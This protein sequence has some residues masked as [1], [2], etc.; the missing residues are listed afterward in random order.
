MGKQKLDQLLKQLE[1]NHAQDIENAAAIFTVAQGAVNQLAA[2]S[3]QP[4]LPESEVPLAG[5]SPVTKADLLERYGSYNACRQAA[6]RAGITF[7][8]TP[9]WA[10]L[11][12]AFSYLLACQACVSTYLQQ[13][14][15]PNLKGV[16]IKLTLSP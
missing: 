5:P 8:H 3:S 2:D 6:K 13:H 10:Q 16:S 7:S 12:T 4:I 1:D 14:P 15:D 9:R 11:V